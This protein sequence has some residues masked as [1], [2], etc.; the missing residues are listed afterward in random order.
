MSI[1]ST[2]S[3]SLR[4][5]SVETIV[6]FMQEGLRRISRLCLCCS[7]D[8]AAERAGRRVFDGSGGARKDGVV[9]S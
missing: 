9:L 3:A 4:T 6:V 5:H 7:L 8:L 1:P 2:W